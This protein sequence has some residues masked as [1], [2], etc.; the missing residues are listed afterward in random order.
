V[1]GVEDTWFFAH[2]ASARSMSGDRPLLRLTGDLLPSSWKRYFS[3][4]RRTLETV[5]WSVNYIE[6]IAPHFA[7]DRVD[8]P[9][10][11]AKDCCSSSQSS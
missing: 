7:I 1:L 3:F 6:R 9:S 5:L 8:S 10:F 2:T 11:D 4:W